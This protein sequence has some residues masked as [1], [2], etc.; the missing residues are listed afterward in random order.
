MADNMLHAIAGKRLHRLLAM[1][2]ERLRHLTAMFVSCV[3]RVWVSS[4]V[5]RLGVTSRRLDGRRASFCGLE[6][7]L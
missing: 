5:V 1:S 7:W 6:G 3:L 4:S 2:S